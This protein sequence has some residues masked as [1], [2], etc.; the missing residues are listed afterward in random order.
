MQAF[1]ASGRELVNAHGG[2]SAL[3]ERL[4]D[5][6]GATTGWR[7]TT[8][9]K[10]VERYDAAGRLQSIAQRT[11]WAHALA[12]DA[13]GRLASVTDASGNVVTFTYDATG[14]RSGFV[15]PG[16]RTY[17]YGY[18]ARGRLISVTYPD[19]AVRTYHYE[20]ASFLHALTGITDENGVRF[21][22]WTYDGMGRA[23]SSR[24][25]GDAEAVTLY[26]GSY[27]STANEGTTTVVDAFG[28][29]RSYYYQGAGGMLRVKRVTQPCPGCNGANA[30]YLFDANG[31]VSSSTDFNGNKTTYTFDLARNLEISRTEAAGTTLARTTTTQWHPAFRLPTKITT[32]SGANG[33]DEVT[34]LAYD[35]QGNLVQK[36]ITS[37]TAQAPVDHH[38][39]RAR[40]GAHR[41]WAADRRCRCHDLHVLR[42]GRSL[43]RV[44]RQCADHCQCAWAGHDVRRL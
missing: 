13:N 39:Q 17:R 24:H 43:R 9:D 34:D 25:A 6:S 32:P 19:N 15:A 40:P 11:G 12:Y 26:Q 35:A 7:L 28:T 31:N 38:V 36:T 2:G 44:P 3:I 29:S 16:N 14:R 33:V 4:A 20:N 37:G 21:A 1:L 23:I 42:D 5:D 8:A 22:T 27:S 30:V 10:D 41:R 18:D